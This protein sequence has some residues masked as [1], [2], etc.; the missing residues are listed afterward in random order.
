MHRP[1]YFGC[2]FWFFSIA[3]EEN[4]VISILDSSD[5]AAGCTPLLLRRD[6]SFLKQIIHA[7]RI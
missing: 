1:T 3:D 5:V 7:S 6:M 2:S 4:H